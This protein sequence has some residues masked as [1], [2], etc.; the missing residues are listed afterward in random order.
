[1]KVMCPTLGGVCS[2]PSCLVATDVPYVLKLESRP[3]AP[4]WPGQV[5]YFMAPSFP[6]KQR[7]VAVLESVAA[8]GRGFREK[9]EAD[10]VSITGKKSLL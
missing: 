4:C 1:M 9:A 2:F 6:D 5:L 3:H 8:G 10:A 7:W